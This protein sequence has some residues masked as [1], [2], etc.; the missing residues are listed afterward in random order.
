MQKVLNINLY[1]KEIYITEIK[2]DTNL[3]VEGDDLI[4]HSPLLCGHGIIGVNRVEVF[5]NN[6]LSKAGGHFAHY[7]KCNGFDYI[8]IKGKSKEPVYIYIDKEMVKI[9]DAQEIYRLSL[10]ETE[11]HI[12]EL[13][14]SNVEIAGIGIAG[15]YEVD[16][17][18]IMFGKEKSCGKNG[19][20]KL[21]GNKKVKCI[22]LKKHEIIINKNK[23]KI[24]EINKH[25][26]KRMKADN[27][28]E[29]FKNDNTCYGCNINC[30]GT[31]I[32]KLEKQNFS[33]ENAIKIHDLCNEYGMDSLIFSS[34]I[35]NNQYDELA[36]EILYKTKRSGDLISSNM[37]KVKE[38]K[39]DIFDKYGFCKFITNKDIISKRE[40][41]DLVRYIK[42]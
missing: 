38:R 32:K 34:L 17:A 31:D 26:C 9:L 5:T 14:D 22:V 41:E 19:L 11:E 28:E 20:G 3:A 13:I 2:N 10:R 21:M 16:F 35:E 8:R 33:R 27:V 29:Y 24:D 37:K 39:K 7:M 1:N 42:S 30:K 23:Q 12:K 15:T 36:K 40:V 18:R 25:I 6:I 4:F